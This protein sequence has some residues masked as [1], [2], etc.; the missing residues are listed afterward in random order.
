MCSV[1]QG[2]QC[3]IDSSPQGFPLEKYNLASLGVHLVRIT[4]DVH[5]VRITLGVRIFRNTL[6]VRRVR[7]TRYRF[8]AKMTY[9]KISSV[10][11][12][13]LLPVFPYKK[14][15]QKFYQIRRKILFPSYEFS[16]GFSGAI[17]CKTTYDTA[18]KIK[19]SIKDFFSKCDQIRIFLR[20]S[21]QI[22]ADF[23]IFTEKILNGKL[24]YLCSLNDI[25]SEP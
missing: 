23:V 22:P 4:L 13:C 3:C 11:L 14:C 24:H 7:I 15:S 25:P 6:G 12:I 20:I 21:P 2:S 18:Q 9:D 16:F 17:I 8:W 5:I 19:L 1:F 10:Y